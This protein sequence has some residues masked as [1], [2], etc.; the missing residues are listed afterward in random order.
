MLTSG[1]VLD[2]GQGWSP[3]VTHW[4]IIGSDGQDLDVTP[5]GM[6]FENYIVCI[7]SEEMGATAGQL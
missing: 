6:S 4:Y 7:A 2:F 5:A 3:A 1:T